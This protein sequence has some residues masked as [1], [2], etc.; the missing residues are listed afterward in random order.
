MIRD[1][2][3][4]GA[5]QPSYS[6]PYRILQRLGKVFVLRMGT[7]EVPIIADHI[8]PA[9]IL[10]DDTPSSIAPVARPDLQRSRI[11]NRSGRN[12]KFTN[13]SQA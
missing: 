5:L 9:C 11:T 6:C 8:K 1:D 7:K 10:S 3:L 12:V 13:F 4:R 2:S